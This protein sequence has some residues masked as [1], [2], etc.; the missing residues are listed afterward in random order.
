MVAGAKGGRKMGFWDPDKDLRPKPFGWDAT[1]KKWKSRERAEEA[2]RRRKARLSDTAIL[3][4]EDR[5]PVFA[6]ALWADATTNDIEGDGLIWGCRPYDVYK[7]RREATP[8]QVLEWREAFKHTENGVF[9]GGAPAHH[10]ALVKK[11]LVLSAEE[12]WPQ[13][14]KAFLL[15]NADNIA[16]CI[17]THAAYLVL[18]AS[19][20]EANEIKTIRR[21]SNN[22]PYIYKRWLD[23]AKIDP[24]SLEALREG[25][26]IYACCGDVMPL[27]IAA[28]RAKKKQ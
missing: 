4:W 22:S 14:A 3:I 7:R 19:F 24:D 12:G 20:Y 15:E 9:Y 6:C 1:M 8:L 17:M 26:E 28:I 5:T 2:V 18:L 27:W 21:E 13:G 11:A 10:L 25:L 16:A 23:P